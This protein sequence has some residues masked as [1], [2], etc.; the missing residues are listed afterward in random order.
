MA[1]FQTSE[2]DAKLTSVNVGPWK[3]VFWQVC[4]GWTTFKNISSVRNEKYEH[5]GL[6]KIKILTFFTETSHEP[7]HFEK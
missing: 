7:E 3:F 5:G 4:E 6:L 1:D 2:V